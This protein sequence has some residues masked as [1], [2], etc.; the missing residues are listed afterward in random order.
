[1]V[2][3]S[4]APGYDLPVLL[5]LFDGANVSWPSNATKHAR[6]YSM[7]EAAALTY[8]Q[9]FQKIGLP[10][11]HALADAKALRAAWLAHGWAKD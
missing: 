8:F 10:Q 11:H 2:L 9:E 3:V 1:V 5:N 6:Y 4:D 7:D